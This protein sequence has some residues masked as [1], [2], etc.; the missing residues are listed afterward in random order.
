MRRFI[1]KVG[2]G[3]GQIAAMM[4]LHASFTLSD[5]TL[6]QCVGIARDAGVGCHIHV[7]EDAAD[8]EEFARQIRHAHR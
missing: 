5:A 2:K 7:A 3:D 1:K 4:G 8:R 6:E